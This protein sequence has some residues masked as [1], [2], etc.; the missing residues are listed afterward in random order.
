MDPK[1]DLSRRATLA[2]VGGAASVGLLPMHASAAAFETGLIAHSLRVEWLTDPVGIDTL[3]PRLRW[4]FKAAEGA[5]NV[6]AAA[7]RVVVAS[8]PDKLAA[9]VGDVWD[10][11]VRRGNRF[12][13]APSKALPLISHT[14][15]WWAVEVVEP[16]GARRWS[17]PARFVTGILDPAEWRGSWIM[18][19]PEKVRGDHVRG[20][21]KELTDPSETAPPLLRRAFDLKQIPRR[22]VVSVCGLGHFELT[23]NGSPVT[24]SVLNPGWTAY[25]TTALYTTYEIESLLRP[26]ANML[27]VR[28]GGGM[29]DVE[30]VAGRKSKFVDSYG[31]PRLF[32]QLSLHYDRGV[33]EHVTSD[34]AWR[35]AEGPIVF[36]SMFAGEDVDARRERA[37]WDLPGADDSGWRAALPAP[38]RKI[39]LKAQGVPPVVVHQRFETVSITEPK[40]GVFVYD[41]G[42][43]FAGRPEMVVRG[44]AGSTVKLTP[45]EV[46]GEDGLAWQRSFNAGPDRWVLYNFTLAGRG[47]ERFVPRFNYHGFRYLQVEGAVPVGRGK[48]DG[49][50]EIVSLAGQ[51]LYADLPQVGTFTCSNK[52]LERTHHLIERAVVSNAYSV[53]TDCPHRE[54]LGWLEQAHLNALTVIYNR[55]ASTM[56]EKM[57]GD[58]ADTQQADGMIPGIAPEY[59]AFLEPDGSDQPARNSPEWGS[60]VVLAPWAAYRAYGDT[61]VLADGYLAM[62]RYVDYLAARAQGHIVDFG[63]GDWYDV[64]PGKLGASQ[65]TSRALTGT[66]T[67][68]QALTTLALVA[69]VLGRPASEAAD[70]RRRAERVREAFNTR[71]FNATTGSYDRGS[72]TAN[73][74]PL[75]LGMVPKGQEGRV[76]DALV[77]AVRASQNGVTAGDVGFHYVVRALTENGRDDV[78]F[79]MMSVTDRPSY[80]Y[81]LARGATALTEAWDADPTKSLNHFMLGHGEGWLFGALGGVQIDFAAVHG[82]QILVA[83]RPVGDVRSVSVTQ[84]SVW[85][86][87]R[88]AW[89]REGAVLTLE[90]D[91]P[92]G[93]AATVI[94][95][96]S[97]PAAIREGAGK[98]SAAPGVRSARPVNGGVELSLASGRYRFAAPLIDQKS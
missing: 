25:D 82:R 18:A 11:G 2:L 95:P 81:Q 41:L 96:T 29:Y 42:Q 13:I 34:E 56:Y 9:R 64:G 55:D 6:A 54:K 83:P 92:A 63:L 20:W 65:L 17:A 3:R 37:G 79:D 22:A 23:V 66:A 46:L 47:D 87:V 86:E 73:A 4:L 44:P 49:K 69:E 77:R 26:G 24:D 51:F 59:T 33:V 68:Y 89:K 88:S 61:K 76:L 70:Y 98:A 5:R 84:A 21:S 15:Y 48:L 72:Q 8:S 57:I 67:S 10:S 31:R 45:A 12:S 16:S 71:F 40:P 90:V 30:K 43:N 74:M 97:D 39:R 78:V 35:V 7:I 27:G 62:R 60:A 19:R 32:L 36:A 50:P 80:G 52:L 1:L 85:G 14:P 38:N 93:A 58:I 53:L 28:L 91:I 94:V 75:A